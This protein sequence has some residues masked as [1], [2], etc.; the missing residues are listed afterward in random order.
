MP[1]PL[2]DHATKLRRRL[3]GDTLKRIRA[4]RRRASVRV[5]QLLAKLEKRIFHP[6]LNVE[7]LRRWCDQLDKNVSTRFAEELG[8][9][10][11]D[12]ILQARMEL[13]GRMLA[14]SDLKVWQIGRQV[15]YLSGHSFG[16]AFTR[17]A[18]GKTP[19]E[20]R[21]QAQAA[22]AG[23][24]PPAPEDLVRNADLHQA[25]A[26]DL[27]PQDAGA[28]AGR[29]RDLAGRISDVYQEPAPIISR[30][31]VIEPMMARKLWQWIEHQP[32][33]A[34]LAAIESQAPAF[35]TPALFHRLCTES[36]VAGVSDDIRG[37]KL[38][39]LA[40]ASLEP[41]AKRLGKSSI[42]LYARV[43][44]VAGLAFR[45]SGYLEDAEE[46]LAYANRILQMMGTRPHP[47][48]TAELCLAQA[49][50]ERDRGNVELADELTGQGIEI[51]ERLTAKLLAAARDPETEDPPGEAGEPPR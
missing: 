20:F 37:Q 42:Y 51:I 31:H 18:D 43:H 34:R 39:V 41:L 50:I 48:V 44:V 30:P 19:T 28:L 9:S 36:L 11:R 17:W 33:E 2:T 4:D 14:A 8:L 32:H 1:E 27:S 12:Y 23:E 24:A 40:M 13:G 35:H 26:G 5:A 45:R 22:P 25:L 21:R 3:E 6:D 49:L 7:S 10:P 46:S 16:R 15:G 47:L 29:L 38:V